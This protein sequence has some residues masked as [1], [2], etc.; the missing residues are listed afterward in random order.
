MWRLQ[1]ETYN[2][3][4]KWGTESFFGVFFS[5]G[6]ALQM[7][8]LW[9][10]M[11]WR[12]KNARQVQPYAHDIHASLPNPNFG[13]VDA[14]SCKEERYWQ[15]SPCLHGLELSV[16]VALND[17]TQAEANSKNPTVTNHQH[18]RS[19]FPQKRCQDWANTFGLQVVWSGGQV[20]R[21]ELPLSTSASCG[22]A[23]GCCTHPAGGH[24]N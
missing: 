20:T 9:R 18:R 5:P 16:M 12:I 2:K 15:V 19:T 17:A 7:V 13:G 3:L 14:I 23:G 22:L 8:G 10:I 6:D 21:V 1:F 4:V 11:H 24:E